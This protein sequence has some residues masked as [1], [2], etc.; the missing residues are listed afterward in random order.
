[1][2]I[3]ICIY[4]YI[5]IF[6]LKIPK[7]GI[8]KEGSRGGASLDRLD[9]LDRASRSGRCLGTLG[10]LDGWGKWLEPQA[11]SIGICINYLWDIPISMGMIIYGNLWEYL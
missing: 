2:Y 5:H 8:P 11:I 6:D 4:I 10:T 1:M 9:S 7:G 3:Y